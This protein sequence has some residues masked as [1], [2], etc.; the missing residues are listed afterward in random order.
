M[1]VIIVVA[2]SFPLP[3]VTVSLPAA[4]FERMA[5]EVEYF[6]FESAFVALKYTMLPA[7]SVIFITMSVSAP[8]VPNIVTVSPGSAEVLS[9]ATLAE[10]NADE[11]KANIIRTTIHVPTI[12]FI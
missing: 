10:A 5:N 4:I 8:D 1:T 9:V 11:I 6:P 2:T 3:A 12:F 7:S